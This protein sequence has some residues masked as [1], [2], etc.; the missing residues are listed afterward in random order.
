MVQFREAFWCVYES[1]SSAVAGKKKDAD[2]AGQRTRLFHA[3][4]GWR[5]DPE[6]E[7]FPADVVDPEEPPLIDYDHP[8]VCRWMVRQDWLEV[9]EVASRVHPDPPVPS[10]D[11][12]RRSL[13]DQL[14]HDNSWSTLRAAV[15]SH[16]RPD[17]DADDLEDLRAAKVS[18][19]DG[20][21]SLLL[22]LAARV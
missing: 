7:A 6:E 19:A 17:V 5:R 10:A 9:D 8:Y 2:K 4:A 22:G 11:S 18:G 3:P 16:K 14:R 12:T 20:Y 21:D 1:G 13:S 15:T